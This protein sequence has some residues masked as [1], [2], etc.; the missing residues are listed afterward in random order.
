MKARRAY[1]DLAQPSLTFTPFTGPVVVRVSDDFFHFPT[2]LG[3]NLL[4]LL[5]ALAHWLEV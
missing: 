5:L 3:Y 2:T 1:L 4:L